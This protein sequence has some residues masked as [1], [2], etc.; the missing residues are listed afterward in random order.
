[1]PNSLQDRERTQ[2]GGVLVF[3]EVLGCNDVLVFEVRDG[4]VVR[5]G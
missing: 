4:V 3:P 2:R 5:S 1:M